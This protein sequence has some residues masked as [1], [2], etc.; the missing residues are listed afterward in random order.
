MTGVCPWLMSGAERISN[1]TW[2]RRAEVVLNFAKFIEFSK[3]LGGLWL[4]LESGQE[5]STDRLDYG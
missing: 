2:N 4:G 1:S 3:W 5:Y